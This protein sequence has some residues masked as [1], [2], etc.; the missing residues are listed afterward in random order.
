[1]YWIPA[2]QEDDEKA[3]FAY[4]PFEKSSW[5]K[6]ASKYETRRPAEHAHRDVQRRLEVRDE[7]IWAGRRR[8][9]RRQK[10]C[11]CYGFSLVYSWSGCHE[12]GRLEKRLV[13]CEIDCGGACAIN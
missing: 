10:D 6:Q 11:G 2:R 8:S 12:P 13:Q 4:R 5:T 3:D 9:P 7:Y 1:M